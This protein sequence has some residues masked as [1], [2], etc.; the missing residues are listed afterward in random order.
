MNGTKNPT[1][2]PHTQKNTIQYNIRCPLPP[3]NVS[4]TSFVRHPTNYA[5]FRGCARER[6]FKL[7]GP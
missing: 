3:K 7:E 6:A 1:H 2:S 5:H 4:N